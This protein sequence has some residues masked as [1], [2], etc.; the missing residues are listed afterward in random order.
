[1][2]GEGH[3]DTRDYFGYSK[4]GLCIS[5]Y[6]VDMDEQSA[7]SGIYQGGRIRDEDLSSAESG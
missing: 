5:G 4:L 6:R 1:M 2:S 3:Q 7:V